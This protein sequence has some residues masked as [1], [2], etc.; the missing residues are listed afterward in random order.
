MNNIKIYKHNI[1][2]RKNTRPVL[3]LIVDKT[4]LIK[5]EKR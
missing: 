3:V 2:L 5:T 4:G 1:K